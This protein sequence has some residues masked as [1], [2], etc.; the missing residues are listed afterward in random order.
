MEL[1]LHLL[2]TQWYIWNIPPYDQGNGVGVNLIGVVPQLITS[3][4]AQ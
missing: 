2:I 1:L 4:W 3:V